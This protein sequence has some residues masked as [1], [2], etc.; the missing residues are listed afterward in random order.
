MKMSAIHNLKQASKARLREDQIAQPLYGKVENQFPCARD[1]ASC[2][3]Y[4]NMMIVFG[5]DRNKA[6]FNDV[7]G[8]TA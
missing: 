5:G 4:G 3:V 7:Y 6:A 1:G 2:G 8:Y